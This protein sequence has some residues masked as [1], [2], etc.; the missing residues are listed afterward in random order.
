MYNSKLGVSLFFK[1]ASHKGK[2]QRN[3]EYRTLCALR[4]FVGKNQLF[5]N[6]TPLQ[7]LLFGGEGTKP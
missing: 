3:P 5:Q 6:N 4:I 1:F 2:T 7:C